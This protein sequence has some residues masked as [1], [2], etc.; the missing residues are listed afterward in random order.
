MRS[1]CKTQMTNSRQQAYLDAMGIEVWSLRDVISAAE[2]DQPIS[3]GIKLGPGS[4]GVLLICEAAD[5]SA[6]RLANDIGRA[7]G[8]VPVWAWPQIDDVSV[9]LSDAVDEHLFTT[10]AIFGETLASQFFAEELPTNL[11]SAQLVLLPAMR[12]ILANA[13]ARRLLW[14]VFC[15]SSM[16]SAN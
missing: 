3:P 8:G 16:V 13:E 5:D 14:S 2:V 1:N 4:G 11:N 12:D 10:V 7:L 6:S 9:Q 15:Q